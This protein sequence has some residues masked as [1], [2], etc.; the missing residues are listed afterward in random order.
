MDKSVEEV[1]YEYY[2]ETSCLCRLSEFSSKEDVRSI[3]GYCYRKANHVAH[4]M[5]FSTS[6][7]S[8]QYRLLL[9]DVIDG[10]VNE[11]VQHGVNLCSQ[12]GSYGSY[13]FGKNK[14]VKNDDWLQNGKLVG[15]MKYE[16]LGFEL[17]SDED[18]KKCVDDVLIENIEQWK[19]KYRPRG[20]K[21]E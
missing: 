14:K 13:V 2:M 12:E 5:D 15:T 21:S 4:M 19:W 18:M 3:F 20:E 8:E 7:N 10:F 1:L 17:P 16:F 11:L 9:G 6:P